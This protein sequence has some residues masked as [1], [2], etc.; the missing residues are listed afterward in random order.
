MSRNAVYPSLVQALS[1]EGIFS[2][3]V[4]TDNVEIYL[5]RIETVL[6]NVNGTDEKAV[7]DITQI[8]TDAINILSGDDLNVVM[9]YAE[10][11]K[12]SLSYWMSE[13]SKN[14]SSRSIQ[15]DLRL[16]GIVALSDAAG[17]TAGAAIGLIMKVDPTITA[18]ISIACGAYS[19]GMAW[20]TGR[21]Y[22]IIDI[23]GLVDRILGK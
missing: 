1:D 12:S 23:Q 11:A 7:N 15:D 22:C 2:N 17:A 5:K 6:Q 21:F 20:D 16:A 14:N 9:S 13:F 8:E 3:E 10:T 19:S 4:F 18:L